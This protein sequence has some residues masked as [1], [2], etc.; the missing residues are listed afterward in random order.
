MA[1]SV[2]VPDACDGTYAIVLDV[3]GVNEPVTGV[4]PV[5]VIVFAPVVNTCEESTVIPVNFTDELK[6]NVVTPPLAV[7]CIDPKS[8][9]VVSVRVCV[10]P[11]GFIKI[12]TPAAFVIAV[13]L[14]SKLPF[15][16]KF[17]AG[18]VHD[19]PQAKVKLL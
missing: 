4:V 12:I 8:E 5:K 17:D 19:V 1:G 18:M 10:P 13:P 6:L 7:S 2:T 9:P 15:K 3:E 11:P 14:T 16:V